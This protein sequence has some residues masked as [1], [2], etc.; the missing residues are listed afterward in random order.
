MNAPQKFTDQYLYPTAFSGWGA[1]EA[2]AIGRVCASDNFTMGYEVEAFERE[3]S[4]WHD[5]KFCIAV[6]SGSSAN[7]VSIA[8]LAELGIIKRGDKALVPA[9]AWSTTYSPIVQHGIDPV[10]IDSDAT[11]CAGRDADLP[12]TYHLKNDDNLS[13]IVTCGILG[14][15]EHGG[16]WAQMAENAGAALHCDNCESIGAREPDGTLTG[17]RGIT[18][19]F[20][21]YFSHQMSAI[22]GGAILTNDEDVAR[23]CR[24]LRAHGWTRGLRMVQQFEDEY[25]FEVMG[26]NVRPLELH[27]AIARVQLKKLDNRIE[28]RRGN[29]AYWCRASEGLPI[30]RPLLRG[31]PSPFCIHFCV[32][33][34][35]T[36]QRLANALRANGIDCRPPIAGSFGRQPYGKRWASQRTPKADEIHD[37]GMAI[38]C[39]PFDGRHLIDMAVKVMREVL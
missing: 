29:Y 17:T 5:M 7:L 24:M 27:A 21:F 37:T 25:R 36:R 13:L 15:P 28:E 10:L 18:N 35:E 20:S 23:T 8:A 33:D 30:E 26:F 32:K 2:A 34:R 14:N 4:A 11:W 39:P 9:L 31:M 12:I 6:N 19:A 38:G 3:F 16:F 22:E 1:E